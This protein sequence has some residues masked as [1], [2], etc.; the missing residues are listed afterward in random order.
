MQSSC[1]QIPPP[2]AGTMA[3]AGNQTLISHFVLLGLFTHTPLH[4]LLFSIIMVMFLVALSG[5]GLM[6]LVINMDS[7]LHNPMYFFLSW[8]S[9]MDL[10]L[11]STIVPRMAADFLR[12]RGSISF[13][14][15]GLQI[16]FFLTL[17]QVSTTFLINILHG[18]YIAEPPFKGPQ[19]LSHI[20]LPP[21]PGLSPK[22]TRDDKHNGHI[23]CWIQLSCDFRAP[24]VKDKK[25]KTQM[26]LFGDCTMTTATSF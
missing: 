21:Q 25:R 7:R 2:T 15:C 9:L 22:G 1:F 8:L 14:G 10:M 11:I 12:G 13:T 19:P 4:L 3:W 17:T 6:I 16:L 18:T 20:A 26:V 24:W 23:Q 5:N